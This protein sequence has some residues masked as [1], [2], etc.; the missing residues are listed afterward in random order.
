ESDVEP[1]RNQ[2]AKPSK[3]VNASTAPLGLCCRSGTALR[4][5]SDGAAKS[6]ATALAAWRYSPRSV[7]PHREP[8]LVSRLSYLS[9]AVWPARQ[10]SNTASA[11]SRSSALVNLRR[12]FFRGWTSIGVAPL[13]SSTPCRRIRFRLDIRDQFTRPDITHLLS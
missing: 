7:A 10:S 8:V 6:R 12:G 2:R 11:C 4:L 3:T 9:L 1:S 13:A 5:W